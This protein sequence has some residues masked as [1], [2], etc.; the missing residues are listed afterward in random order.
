MK[1]G[2][3]WSSVLIREVSFKRFHFIIN[4]HSWDIASIMLCTL[5]GWIVGNRN[6]LVQRWQVAHAVPNGQSANSLISSKW[7]LAR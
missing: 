5:L 6:C 1:L 7:G 3:A 4:L 2:L